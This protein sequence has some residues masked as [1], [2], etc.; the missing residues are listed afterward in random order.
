ME[1]AFSMA[2]KDWIWKHR[3]HK[4]WARYHAKI[5]NYHPDGVILVIFNR[6]ATNND[7]RPRFCV[8]CHVSNGC[9]R[10]Y[11]SPSPK[12]HKRFDDLENRK[13]FTLLDIFGLFPGTSNGSAQENTTLKC[14][15]KTFCFEVIAFMSTKPPSKLQKIINAKL[16]ELSMVWMYLD[17]VVVFPASFPDRI[18]HFLDALSIVYAHGLVM[19]ISKCELSKWGKLYLVTLLTNLQLR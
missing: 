5:K 3:D 10:A 4:A 13:Q 17:D 1:V 18:E 7:S 12:N 8:I 9:M 19:K 16:G 14:W 11:C 2:H 15:Y 6:T